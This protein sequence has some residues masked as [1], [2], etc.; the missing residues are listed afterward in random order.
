MKYFCSLLICV[1]FLFSALT[2]HASEITSAIQKEYDALQGFR[3]DFKQQL[4]NSASGEIETREG[5]IWFKQPG[6]V[7]WETKTP[8]KELLIVGKNVVWDYFPQEET[9]MKYATS[10]ILSSKNMIKFIS[11]KARLEEDFEIEDMG[12][13]MGLRKL[14]LTPI[15][16]EPSL[17][18]ATIWVDPATNLLRSILLVDFYGNGN[19]LGLDNI[20]R[21][22][23]LSDELFKF[24]PPEDVVVQDNTHKANTPQ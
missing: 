19:K 4:K 6:L 15:A 17:V 1:F 23:E 16:P 2:L 14:M 7:R 8:E 9:A 22:A 20:V 24:V 3:V 13:E 10:D 5:C 21:N 12:M 18:L 11:G